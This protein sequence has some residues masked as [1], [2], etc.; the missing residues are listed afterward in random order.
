VRLRLR[1]WQREACEQFTE[2]FLSGHR[3]AL[4]MAT[5]GAGKT[6]AAL[7][8]ATFFRQADRGARVAVLV[9]TRH[10]KG[11]WANKAAQFGLQLQPHYRTGQPLAPGYQGIVATYQQVGSDPAAFRRFLAGAIVVLDEIHHTA[12]GNVW[13][14]GIV[15]ATQLAGFN[16]ALSGTPFRSDDSPIPFLHYDTDGL[17]QPD[18]A[19]GYADA[20]RDRVCRPV[21]FFAYGGEVAWIENDRPQYGNLANDYEGFNR[22]LRVAL[23]P[24]SGWI[25]PLFEDAHAMLMDVRREQPDAGGLVVA[26]DQD[27]ARE[28][29]EMVYEVTCE[30]PTVAI[31]DNAESSRQITRFAGN[32]DMWLVAVKMVSEGVDV[33]RLRVGVYASNVRTRMFFRQFLGRI[34]RVTPTPAGMQV[35]Y[36][37]L[38]A[39]P[40][41]MYL[42]EEVEV[43]RQHAARQSSHLIPADSTPWLTAVPVGE[44]PPA[45]QVNPSLWQIKNSVNSGVK[46]LILNG[47][48][49]P[50]LPGF[51]PPAETRQRIQTHA[52][53]R[54]SLDEPTATLAESAD[55]LRREIKRLVG[56]YCARTGK[57][58]QEVYA[59]L[60]RQQGVRSQSDCSL[61]QLQDRAR[62]VS[63]W[64]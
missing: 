61:S 39:T 5:P 24:G 21:A 35:G 56:I 55:S 1:T 9:P 37:Y 53:T 51:V 43:E 50:L 52:E 60:N 14:D 31:S 34:S 64:L 3:S 12:H 18:Y 33:P 8:A 62:I 28:L 2:R 59:Q 23:H 49:L 45:E 41:L 13:G 57:T 26:I 20:I 6:V 48:Q 22:H 40:E 58:F 63:G 36:C 15:Q 46:A 29:A 47:G 25:R 16:L 38:P 4:W 32:R 30:K 11:Q 42:A 7:Q 19:Y 17:S 27:H 54:F 44:N 10:L